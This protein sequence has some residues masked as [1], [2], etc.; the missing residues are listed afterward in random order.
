[1]A[2]LRCSHCGLPMTETEAGAGTCPTCGAAL[3]T[4]GPAASVAGD[5]SQGTNARKV[6]A[7]GAQSLWLLVGLAGLLLLLGGLWYLLSGLPF[8]P[9]TSRPDGKPDQEF[10]QSGKQKVPASPQA[11]TGDPAKQSSNDEPKPAEPAPGQA[12]PRDEETGKP[13]QPVPSKQPPANPQ[14][15]PKADA[16]ESNPAQPKE[17]PFR[18]DTK[19]VEPKKPDPPQPPAVADKKPQ[20]REQDPFFDE[21]EQINNPDGE[22]TVQTLN[23]GTKLKLKG[24]VGTLKINGLN[25]GSV[26]D[27]L[28][29]EAKEIIITGGVNGESLLRLNAP[30]GKVIFRADINGSSLVQVF[31][32]DGV[33]IF[34]NPDKQPG[35]G[36]QINGESQLDIVAREV[37]L[38]G[39][40]NGTHTEIDVV[41]S[42]GG[43][44]SFHELHGASRLLYSNLDPADP[45]PTIQ[46]GKIMG[47][48]QF[49]KVE[50]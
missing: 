22:H 1:M 21:V 29:L 39:P 14:T 48:A 30:Q 44:L 3:G 5:S 40:V 38:R 11:K 33:V 43:K 7:K 20:P 46:A 9:S 50:K 12:E 32:P 41:L 49:K 31:A 42:K 24:K 4:S 2:V 36:S 19:K 37:D 28:H 47:A 17:T 8:S 27:A 10:A 25:G 23:D 45:T 18:D 15:P 13:Q 6:P 35:Q 34:G 16:P 26:L